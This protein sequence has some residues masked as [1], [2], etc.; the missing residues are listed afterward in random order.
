MMD[1]VGAKDA[2]SEFDKISAPI[3]TIMCSANIVITKVAYMVLSNGSGDYCLLM[4]D[5]DEVSVFGTAGIPSAKLKARK[6]KLSDP[7][8]I[9]KC[10]ILL[11]TF[12]I[13]HGSYM[14]VSLLN[15]VPIK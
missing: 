14:K 6:L 13:K 11:Y 3:N 10:S 7:R 8:I 5:I 1:K 15:N 4:I 2:P 12:Y 9:A